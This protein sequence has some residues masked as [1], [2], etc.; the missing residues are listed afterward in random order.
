MKKNKEW[1]LKSVK[2][3]FCKGYDFKEEPEKKLDR[4]EGSI[5][6]ENGDNEMFRFKIR[7]DLADRY[8]QLISEDVVTSATELGERLIK[9]LGLEVNK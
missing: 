1:R 5:E 2:V 6:F 3:D 4:Y 7:P 9:S 8:I